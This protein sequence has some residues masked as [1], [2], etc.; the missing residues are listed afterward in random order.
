MT[1]KTF[2]L[3]TKVMLLW[4]PLLLTSPGTAYGYADPGSGAF[5]YQAA[6]AVFLGGAY[7]VRNFLNRIWPR[8][9]K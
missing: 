1:N 9:S 2:S 6:Y 5:V 4:I 3:L 7:Y 8:R